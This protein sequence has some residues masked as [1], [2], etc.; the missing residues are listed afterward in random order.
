M[1]DKSIWS[2]LLAVGYVVFKM[3]KTFG[4]SYEAHL[5]KPVA[6]DSSWGFPE[7]PEGQQQK[8]DSTP[9]SPFSA[10]HSSRNRPTHTA[11][12]SQKKLTSPT[13][14]GSYPGVGQ[15]TDPSEKNNYPH[16]KRLF[17]P[18]QQGGYPGVQQLIAPNQP[19][20]AYPSRSAIIQRRIQH[21]LSKHSPAKQAFLMAELFRPAHANP[22][23]NALPATIKPS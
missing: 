1:K 14:Q 13:R 16:S 22:Q 10:Q 20:K 19:T 7:S 6:P 3:L 2:L 12:P 9:S 17:S 18:T 8:K 15:L 11:H 4:K 21:I 5:P 23:S